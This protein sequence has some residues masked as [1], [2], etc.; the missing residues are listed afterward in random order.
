M[1]D[2]AHLA[3]A[4]L[5]EMK[6]DFTDEE[7][8][9]HQVKVQ[10]NPETLKV[11]FSNQ[12]VTPSGGGSQ[13]GTPKMQF[14]GAGTTKLSV[15]LWFDV[16]APLTE[17]EEQVDDVRRLTQKVAYF[18]TPVQDK[19]DKNKFIPPAV[20]FLWGSFQFDGIMD[21]LEE[22]LEFFSNEG[23]P[24]RASVTFNL[25]QQ[26]IQKF[27]FGKADVPPGGGGLGG[28]AAGTAHLTPTPAG[29]TLQ[30][31]AA[32]AGQGANWQNIATA[33]GIE[34]PRLLQPGQLVNLNVNAPT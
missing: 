24:L 32:N 8:N 1:P 16:N 17:D 30:G 5:H 20:R 25:S 27:A 11:S 9:G 31:M 3:K 28:A 2:P 33:N 18:I 22:S 23:R 13:T 21:S 15:Q 29:S 26:K 7:P 34:N 10:L 12:V 14:V 19:K 6:S 4:E